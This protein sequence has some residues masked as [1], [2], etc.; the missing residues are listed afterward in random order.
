MLIRFIGRDVNQTYETEDSIKLR[1]ALTKCGI[2]PSTVI[3]SYDGK[4][5]PMSTI[6]TNDIELSVT[7]VSSG[8]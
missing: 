5:I 1:E 6:L 2:L 8:G 4:V 3:V 7:T